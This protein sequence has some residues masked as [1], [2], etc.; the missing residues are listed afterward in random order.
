[1]EGIKSVIERRVNSLG[2]SEPTIQSSKYGSDNHIIVQ[3]PTQ[4]HSDLDDAARKAK[5][6]EDIKKA[7][8]TIGK[9]VQLE[10][11]EEKKSVTDA[12]RAERKAIAEKA[13]VDT[14][15][16]PFATVGAKY[17]DNYENVGFAPTATG[18]IPK[19][20]SFSGVDTITTFP[21]ITPVFVARGEESYVNGGSGE[22][23]TSSNPGYAIMELTSKNGTGT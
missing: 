15:T 16:T 11:R 17:R 2:L 10:F 7:K 22:I 21:Y 23:I 19:E 6:A 18:A 12:D 20:I 1:V 3:I 5:N 8:E 9:V 13:L 4:A 14:K